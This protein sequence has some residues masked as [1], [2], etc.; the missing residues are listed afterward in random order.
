MLSDAGEP[1]FALNTAVEAQAK[2]EKAERKVQQ[3]QLDMEAFQAL[4][5]V[6]RVGVDRSS[7]RHLRRFSVHSACTNN[8]MVLAFASL[9]SYLQQFSST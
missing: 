5:E 3:L 6:R 9:V 1:V 7:G 4:T 8:G 2:L